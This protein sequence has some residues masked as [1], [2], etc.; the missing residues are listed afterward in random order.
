MSTRAGDSGGHPGAP[1]DP[2]GP[3]DFRVPPQGTA[4]PGPARQRMPKQT[5]LWTRL[6]PWVPEN[7]AFVRN[8]WREATLFF[9]A[10]GP[11]LRIPKD[12]PGSGWQAPWPPIQASGLHLLSVWEGPR[13]CVLWFQL[14]AT[15]TWPHLPTWKVGPRIC[16]RFPT[17]L[18]SP[19]G[20]ST[21]ERGLRSCSAQGM[22]RFREPRVQRHLELEEEPANT[23]GGVC[24]ARPVFR[25]PESQKRLSHFKRETE[26][27]REAELLGE[28]A[29]LRL[30]HTALQSTETKTFILWPAA[31]TRAGVRPSAAANPLLWPWPSRLLRGVV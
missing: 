28:D 18:E 24:S 29:A 16:L 30:G 25:W 15:T 19:R 8:E 23:A 22:A 12:C 4:W 2:G 9:T 3:V 31:E 26:N 13:A 20:S 11:W 10:T 1:L 21:S 6:G 17:R 7:R 14:S 27:A 5:L